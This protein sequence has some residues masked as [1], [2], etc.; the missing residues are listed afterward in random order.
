MRGRYD[1]FSDDE[2]FESL[3]RSLPDFFTRQV[4]C[5]ATGGILRPSTLANLDSG[6][7]KLPKRRVGKKVVYR[8]S[9]FIPW[10][11]NTLAYTPNEPPYSCNRNRSLSCDPKILAQENDAEYF[12]DTT[13]NLD[14]RRN[15]DYKY[16]LTN[17]F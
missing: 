2:F 3:E 9:D 14:P 7:N 11:R 8:K 16:F 10:L 15:S 4:A 5:E 17:R 13:C 6:K 12:D 1:S